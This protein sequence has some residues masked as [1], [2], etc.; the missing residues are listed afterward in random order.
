M[1]S[2]NPFAKFIREDGQY[3]STEPLTDAGKDKLYTNSE[4]FV[5]STLRPEKT[6]G[7]YK[8]FPLGEHEEWTTDSATI[9]GVNN[10]TS[11]YGNGIES[12]NLITAVKDIFTKWIEGNYYNRE[13]PSQSTI[14]PAFARNSHIKYQATKKTNSEAKA[15]SDSNEHYRN[16]PYSFE[17]FYKEMYKWVYDSIAA[18]LLTLAESN[19]KIVKRFIS[20]SE[21]FTLSFLLH[22][23]AY[24]PNKA[25]EAQRRKRGK[26]KDHGLDKDMSITIPKLTSH[27]AMTHEENDFS[28]LINYH[29]SAVVTNSGSTSAKLNDPSKT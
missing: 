3:T 17:D 29:K 8:N 10:P 18:Y 20:E 7:D 1:D 2:W 21:I 6:I 16:F 26:T 13:K 5:F 14:I 12:K 4:D 27:T 24:D 23:F 22:N 15:F 25:Y 19:L 11:V 9:S 28:P